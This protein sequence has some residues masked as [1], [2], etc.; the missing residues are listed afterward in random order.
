MNRYSLTV[1]PP[2]RER[3]TI[4]PGELVLVE[5]DDDKRG[6]LLFVCPCGCGEEIS[7]PV[8]P[9][10]GVADKERH[11]WHFDPSTVTLRPSVRWRAGCYSH[12][13]IRAGGLVDWCKDTGVPGRT[14]RR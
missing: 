9:D 13:W 11:L 5:F 4:A 2:L 1:R 3:Q 8:H 12:F 14:R 6:T 10:R 7:L